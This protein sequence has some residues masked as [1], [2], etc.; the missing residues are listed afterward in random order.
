M[1]LEASGIV[2]SPVSLCFW[3]DALDAF[4][5]KRLVFGNSRALGIS[6]GKRLTLWSP[7]S[8]RSTNL[9]LNQY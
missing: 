2:G 7:Y 1:L 6:T 4:S 3:G 5:T 8:I 9:G